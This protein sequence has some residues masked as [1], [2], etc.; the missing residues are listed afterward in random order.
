MESLIRPHVEAGN[1][2]A[3]R[4]QLVTY[5]ASL[6][7]PTAALLAEAAYWSC[8]ANDF[9]QAAVWYRAA[10][11]REPEHHTYHYNLATTLRITGDIAGA[12]EAL[13]RHL[14]LVP[15]DGEAHWL[16]AQLHTQTASNNQVASLKALLQRT[17]PPKQQV[18]AWYALGKSL[19]DIGDYDGA[20]SAISKGASLR[21]QYLNYD[22]SHDEAIFTEIADTFNTQWHTQTRS[23]QGGNGNT[24]IVGMP[25]CGSTLTEQLLSAHN[26][27]VAGGELNTFS[28][29][30][31]QLVAQQTRVTSVLSAIKASAGLDFALLGERYQHA[32]REYRSDGAVFTD[33]L[34][35]NFLYVG[36]IAKA[37]PEARFI[38][39]ERDPMDV[40]WSV[41]KHLFTHTYP[42][43]YQLDEIVRYYRGYRQLM[44]HWQTLFADR[45][46][47]VQYEALVQDPGK[48]T[49]RLADF[50]NLEFEPQSL[51]FYRQDTQVT[52]GSATQVRQPIYQRSVGGW[53]HYREQLAACRTQLKS[54][55]LL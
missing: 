46:L 1:F 5:M 48:Q 38:V 28:A 27:V 51:Q 42:F 7:T 18:H 44:A 31:M 34:P 20:F 2:T 50:I 16:R 6:A 54:A 29:Q 24:F 15:E 3:A 11:E 21:R 37:M 30:M 26:G 40:V 47:T 17:L 8:Q 39:M 10:C 33:K 32:T 13:H 12:D 55:G 25:R 9:S 52:T 35:L 14:A 23:G 43:S 22:V 41:Y 4:Q 19:E 45:M 49:Q 36:L 53:T